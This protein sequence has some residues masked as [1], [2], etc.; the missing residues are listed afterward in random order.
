MLKHRSVLAL[1]AGV[2]LILGLSACED[3]RTPPAAPED[4]SYNQTFV[5]VNEAPAAGQEI[6][7]SFLLASDITDGRL[8]LWGFLQPDA[9]LTRFENYR[10]EID[11]IS[12][13]NE[14][15]EIELINGDLS[16]VGL[17]TKIT[18]IGAEITR[19]QGIA[20]RTPEQQDSLDAFIEDR[21]SLIVERDNL[22]VQLDAWK[23][24]V[25]R[26][27]AEINRR[28]ALRDLLDIELDDMYKVSIRLDNETA[29]YYPKSIFFNEDVILDTAY[30][31]S[32]F[33]NVAISDTA[34]LDLNVHDVAERDSLKNV[35]LSLSADKDSIR[36]FYS[37]MRLEFDNLRSELLPDSS[38]KVWGQGFYLAPPNE[39]GL[40]GVKMTLDLNEFVVADEGWDTG[41]P[42]ITGQKPVRSGS[43]Q[44]QYPIR[45]MIDKLN[46]SASHTLHFRFGVAGSDT[47][48][49]ASLYVVYEEAGRP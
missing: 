48:L 30:F 33:I 49:T 15:L 25:A 6:N 45:N 31:D 4:D 2:V 7:S 43:Y 46:D 10:D 8:F 35:L 27:Y 47:W 19:L 20:G 12:G 22:M 37:A 14:D 13:L 11:S 40:R 39:D 41:E 36:E 5:L 32:S 42:F 26:N 21:I 28:Y 29:E 23:V 24:E 18:E 17:G 44:D 38:R 3:D 34:L 16:Y 9:E 1:L